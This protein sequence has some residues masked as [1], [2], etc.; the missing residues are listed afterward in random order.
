MNVCVK[1]CHNR[2]RNEVCR[3]VTP[4]GHVRTYVRADPYIPCDGI[5]NR[6]TNAHNKSNKFN[7][8][9]R[10]KATVSVKDDGVAAATA[11]AFK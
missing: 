1:F 2:L 11:A 4:L 10:P 3:T 8:R 6:G 5:I 7:D 9:Q